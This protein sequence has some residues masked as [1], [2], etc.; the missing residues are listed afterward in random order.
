[1]PLASSLARMPPSVP[2]TSPTASPTLPPTSPIEPPARPPPNIDPVWPLGL[3]CPAAMTSS[4]IPS[5]ARACCAARSIASSDMALLSGVLA[6]PVPGPKIGL[7]IDRAPADVDLEVEMA[8][9]RAGIAGLAHVADDLADV[10]QVP[11][12]EGRGMD[13]VCVPVLAPLPQPPE[14]DVVAVEPGVVGPLHH[15]AGHG[16]SQGC[17]TPRDHVEALVP[18]PTIAGST[19]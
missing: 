19:E 17:A 18:A 2:A 5:R 11:L 9:D 6:V 4:P 15:S 10:H 1:M 3:N 12:L 7:R 13:H 14:D 8:A 16:R